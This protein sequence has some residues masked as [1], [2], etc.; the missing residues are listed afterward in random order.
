MLERTDFIKKQI[1][2]YFPAEGD[3]LSFKN[4]NVL[5]TDKDG[6]VK[7]QTTCYRLFI[8]FVVGDTSI[9][10][11]LIK[12]AK[13]FGF[14]ICFMNQSFKINNFLGS[15]ME[16]NTLLRKRQYAYSG[17]G[18]GQHI[19]YN[20]V[21][22]QRE[23]LNMIRVKDE[24][25]KAAIEKLDGYLF[26]LQTQIYER[27]SLLGLEGSASRVYFAQ[28]FNN[29]K[30]IGRKPR[31]KPDIINASLDIGYTVLF[32]LIDALVNV[33]GFDE[34]YGVLHTCFYMR[35]SLIC[36][37]ME[38]FRPIVDYATRKAIALK[39][40]KMEDFTVKNARY[41]L[42]WKQ[43]AIYTKIYLTAL[44]VYKNEIFIYIRDYYRA[45]MKNLDEKDFPMF[46][47][48]G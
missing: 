17:M 32:N 24:L 4:D 33:Y 13:K 38:P 8:L 48:N 9:T 22:N 6:K 28:M 14:S 25:I 16:G 5:I 41:L 20:K 12:R 45:F 42:G 23:A 19:I 39:Q 29:A 3:K 18:L 30:W 37:L 21:L 35:K 31:I 11:G 7:G 46:Y 27:E 36:D 2:F 34:Y 40:I 43:S 47:Y 1:I 15:R 10:T 44:L 26:N